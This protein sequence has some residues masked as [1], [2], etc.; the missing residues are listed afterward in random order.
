VL[1]LLAQPQ[2]FSTYKNTAV[3]AVVVEGWASIEQL[4]HSTAHLKALLLSP[5][6]TKIG[7]FGPKEYVMCCRP[8]PAPKKFN[9]QAVNKE[10]SVCRIQEKFHALHERLVRHE[11]IAVVR[12][13]P[14]AGFKAWVKASNN[15]G[16]AACPHGTN[17]H[18]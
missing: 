4:P 8:G 1:V 15:N 14:A 11:Q 18:R 12:T 6:T 9:G 13:P 7:L 3:K 5:S 17:M 2:N 16:Y 10:N